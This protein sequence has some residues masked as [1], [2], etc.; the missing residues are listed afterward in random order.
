MDKNVKV[1]HFPG[2]AIDGLYDY[3]KPLLEKYP[4]NKTLHVG[5]S[6]T[7]N[8]PSKLVVGKLLDLKKF[9]EKTL[10]RM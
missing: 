7:V 9:I 4:D 2:A 3:I 5:T 6:N 10:I 8:E 1:K